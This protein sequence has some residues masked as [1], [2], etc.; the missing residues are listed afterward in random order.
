[1]EIIQ[2]GF[3]GAVVFGFAI[4]GIWLGVRIIRSLLS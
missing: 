3:V 2:D 4:I 1:M